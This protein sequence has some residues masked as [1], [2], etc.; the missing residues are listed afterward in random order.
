MRQNKL[1]YSGIFILLLSITSCKV[2]PNY[3]QPT[4]KSPEIFSYQEKGIDS[5]IDLKWWEIFKDPKLDSL[6]KVGLQ[7][8]KDVLIAASRI[9]EARANLG[10]N[11]A[12]YGPSIG[13]QAG[14]GSS[15]MISNIV[16]DNQIDNFSA[17]ATFNWELDF[18]GKYRRSTESAKAEMLSSFYGKRVVEIGL[19]SE[20]ARS[21][22]QLINY[23]TSLEISESTLKI[24]NNALTIIQNRFDYGNT[25]II[26]VNQAQIQLAIAQA[27]IPAYKRQIKFAENNLS[28][29]LGKNPGTI[30]TTKTYE[31]YSFPETIPAGIPSSLLQRRPDL[32]ESEQLYKRQNALIGVATAM[33]F[34]SISLT[35]LLG[36]GS[37][38][39]SS[40]I[41]NGLG[42]G[43]GAS[44]L[45]PIFD[46]GKN[47]RRVDI[48]RARA[49]Q[50]LLSYEKSVILAFSDVDNS[51]TEID[52]YKEELT[53]YKFML[54]AA[55]NASKLSYE[56]YYQG[57]TSYLEVI[58]NQ[59][60]EFEA[61][62]QYSKNYEELLVSYVNLYQALGGG[63][64]SNEELD[65]YAAQ[66]ANEQGV[67][68]STIDKDALIYSGQVVDYYLTPAQEKARKEQQKAQRKLERELK[69]E[70]KN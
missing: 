50:Y 35:G 61:E 1:I 39:M 28:V 26:D 12:N 19:I 46:W 25:N 29:L 63:W 58:F 18:W 5:I 44:L 27:A 8:N 24:R 47:A 70:A 68:V 56:R 30:T 34:P 49:Q 23:K 65:K 40:I 59:Q 42:W 20:I 15:N 6:I 3:Q 62:L 43:A 2:G 33:R 57:V 54:D 10:F 9:E 16:Q 13:V 17:T 4:V 38:E 11:K 64:I 55:K 7:N 31:S 60:K 48:E 14:A 66:V 45:S 52:T 36:V 69:K 37:T 41:T 21:Y 67:D 51:L 22:F 53:A 32:L